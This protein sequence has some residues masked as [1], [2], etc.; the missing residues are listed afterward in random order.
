MSDRESYFKKLSSQMSDFRQ[1]GTFSDVK[2]QCKNGNFLC[3]KFVL[4]AR[5]KLFKKLFSSCHCLS[6]DIICQ[7]FSLEAV[8][9]VMELLYTG[10]LHPDKLSHDLW[11]E[12]IYVA[13]NLGLE[14]TI[15]DLEIEE[16]RAAAPVVVLLS[17]VHDSFE[18]KC[19]LDQELQLQ[20]ETLQMETDGQA[21]VNEIL[22][23]SEEESFEEHEEGD[24]NVQQTEDDEDEVQVEKVVEKTSSEP[25]VTRLQ[26]CPFC[27]KTFSVK[28]ALNK[29][30]ERIHNTTV[31]IMVQVQ[32]VIKED[33]KNDD[34]V[35][36]GGIGNIEDYVGKP[37]PKC[38]E[39]FRIKDLEDHVK[40]CQ[41][42]MTKRAEEKSPRRVLRDR[43]PF[44]TGK[45]ES[46]HFLY[47]CFYS[48]R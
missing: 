10:G 36:S 18:T 47:Q 4:S 48:Q 22:D 41:G 24:G 44:Q 29:H 30:L 46:T 42:S 31:D 5:S 20:D 9:K 23:L 14:M 43:G 40:D 25:T 32:D 28:I 7:D 6:E 16:T 34:N 1:R 26:K 3:H 12:M 8:S 27:G 33:P 45:I 15:P 2:I 39:L 35:V 38:D 11:L 17:P 37:C 21:M 13:R 19:S